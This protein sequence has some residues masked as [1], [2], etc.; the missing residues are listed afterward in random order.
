MGCDASSI[1]SGRKRFRR[2]F[3]Y[4]IMAAEV[5]SLREAE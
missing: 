2:Y 1:F 5:R 4:A 3:F